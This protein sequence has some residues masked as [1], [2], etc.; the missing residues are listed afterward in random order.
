MRTRR[1]PR[2]GRPLI[3][4]LAMLLA[5]IAAHAVGIRIAGNVAAWQ[6]WLHTRHRLAILQHC[7]VNF[8]KE[9]QTIEHAHCV[10]PRYTSH[11]HD[12]R[13]QKRMRRTR[14]PSPP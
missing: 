14:R 10:R 12:T 13:E 5:M 9:N 4:A 7:A 6:R 1:W 11:K 2:I 3:I 8:R